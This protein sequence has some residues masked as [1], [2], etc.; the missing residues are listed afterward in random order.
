MREKYF[1]ASAAVVAY[2]MHK[3]DRIVAEEN[4]GGK[5]VAHTIRMTDP[6]VAYKGVHAS[7]G[8]IARA[9]PVA[10]LYEQN[11]V[12]H[13]GAFPL[14]EDQLCEYEAALGQPSPDR[15]DA[16]AWALTE[17]LLEAKDKRGFAW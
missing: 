6:K 1:W 16:C 15:Y 2:H 14:L 12:H 13:V 17:L 9:E 5:M 3:A 11:R 4:Q 8:K 7:R 10:A